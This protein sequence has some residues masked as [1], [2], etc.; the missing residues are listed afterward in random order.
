[1][2]NGIAKENV[3]CRVR[4]YKN[5]TGEDA[6]DG[7]VLELKYGTLVETGGNQIVPSI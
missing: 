4:F 7:Y 2:S 1:M 3:L 6:I 5:T